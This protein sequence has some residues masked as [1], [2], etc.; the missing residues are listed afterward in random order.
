M[1][2]PIFD[3]VKSRLGDAIIVLGPERWD[4]TVRTPCIRW[5]PTGARVTFP[6]LANGNI[7][8]RIWAVE[9]EIWAKDLAATT[10]LTDQLRAV[11]HDIGSHFTFP[12]DALETWKTGGRTPHGMFC[13]FPLAIRT[14]IARS[15]EPALVITDPDKIITTGAIV[16]PEPPPD[17][18]DPL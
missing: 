12:P 17:P 13:S 3:D 9:V 4:D 14:P 7:G 16:R 10:A 1:L 6:P 8:E 5:R 2:Q 11:L 15:L 18:L